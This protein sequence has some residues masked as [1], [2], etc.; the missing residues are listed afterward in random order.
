MRRKIAKK[1]SKEE[2]LF[3]FVLAVDDLM[4]NETLLCKRQT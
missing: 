1:P 2:E 3:E 4:I